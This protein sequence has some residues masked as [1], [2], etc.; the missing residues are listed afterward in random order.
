ESLARIGDAHRIE[1]KRGQS[2]HAE[3]RIAHYHRIRG[4]PLQIGKLFGVDEINFRFERRVEAEFPRA[5]FGKDR[6]VASL[7]GVAS[8]AEHVRNLSLVH[9][10][11]GLRFAH[12]QLRAVL[13]LL[14]ANWKAVQ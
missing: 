7:D 1:S 11:G 3:I 9:K 10:D 14:T 2:H 8:G 4:A 12:N 6:R 13:D 5:K